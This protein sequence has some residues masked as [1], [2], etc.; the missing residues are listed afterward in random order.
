MCIDCNCGHYDDD[1]GDK[2]HIT[3]ETLRAA[4][5]ASN[6][7]VEEVARRIFLTAAKPPLEGLEGT[8]QERPS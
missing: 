6:T 7:T 4:A 3:T 8:S 2:R 5:A 1:H